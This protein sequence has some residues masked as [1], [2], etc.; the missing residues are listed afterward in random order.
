M[1]MVMMD[2]THA[3]S[4]N[5]YT[6]FKLSK[7]EMKEREKERKGEREMKEREAARQ[8][9]QVIQVIRPLERVNEGKREDG[10]MFSFR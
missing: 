8:L 4:K 1:V 9:Q 2:K 3:H 7:H 6:N 10:Q 5:E